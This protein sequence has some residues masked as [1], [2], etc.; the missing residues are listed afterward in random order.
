MS[1]GCRVCIVPAALSRKLE[2]VVNKWRGS[3]GPTGLPVCSG[4][5]TDARTSCEH[6]SAAGRLAGSVSVH[7]SKL[8]GFAGACVRIARRPRVGI[9]PRCPGFRRIRSHFGCRRW[10]RTNRRVV[11]PGASPSAPR[12]IHRPASGVTGVRVQSELAASTSAGAL[13]GQPITQRSRG[14]S[15]RAGSR[16]RETPCSY[17]ASR[18]GVRRRVQSLVGGAT[19]EP[20]RDPRRFLR[21][22]Q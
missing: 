11:A 8:R 3:S 19:S 13:Q 2:R 6:D 20:S 15:G 14:R 5:A 12:R 9:A 16:P 4:Q 1:L 17:R 21:P 18:A 10:M 7:G 22:P